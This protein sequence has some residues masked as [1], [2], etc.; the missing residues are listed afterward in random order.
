MKQRMRACREEP[1]GSPPEARHRGDGLYVRNPPS[2]VGTGGTRAGG[3]GTYRPSPR[4]RAPAGS[5]HRQQSR[6]TPVA[7]LDHL[8]EGRLP[9]AAVEQLDRKVPAVADLS[10]Q[11]EARAQ[12]QDPLPGVD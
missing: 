8:L 10:Q 4:W 2:W 7:A 1:T 12:R 3:F 11:V 5:R 6:Q 9:V